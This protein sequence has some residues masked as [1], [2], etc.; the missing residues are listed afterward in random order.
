IKQNDGASPSF[1][2]ESQ[3]SP[4]RSSSTPLLNR[5]LGPDALRLRRW[6]L[7]RRQQQFVSS[8]RVDASFPPYGIT[9]GEATGRWSDGR[10][11]PDYLASF[12]GISQIPPILRATADF[13]HGANFAIADATVLGA[14]PESRQ[15]KKQREKEQTKDHRVLSGAYASLRRCRSS[16][17]SFPP[18]FFFFASS[19]TSLSLSDILFALEEETCWQWSSDQIQFSSWLSGVD[20]RLE[21][22]DGLEVGF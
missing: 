15:K 5:L 14:P 3:I 12:M 17:P 1:N 10:I 20:V 19:P 6:S 2:G 8:N 16:F 9:L 18:P 4:L 11:V 7:R 21:W 13:S 22:R